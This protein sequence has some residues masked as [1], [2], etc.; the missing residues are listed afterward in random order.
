METVKFTFAIADYG[1]IALYFIAIIFLGIWG[2]RKKT[3]SGKEDFLLAGRKLTLPVFVATL[4][5]TWYGN[6]LGVG[7]FV[8]SNGIVAWV[9][10]GLPYYIAAALYA[11]LIAKKVRNTNVCTIPEQIQ[12]SYGT[13]AGKVSSVI[14]LLITIP[15]AYI[16]ML[17]IIIRMFVGLEL[18]ICIIIGAF[19]SLIYLY[20]GGF[21]ADIMA[22]TAQFVL[23]FLG[24]GI[25]LYFSVVKLGS[26][27][28]MFSRLPEL[29]KDF[30][31]GFPWQI[32][33]VW[34]IIAL[35]TFVD[36]GFHQRCSAAKSP[37]T[38]RNG[39]LV[40][41]LCWIVFDFLTL[42]TGLYA[43]AYFHDLAPITSFPVLGENILP[44]FAKGFFV[45]SMLSPIMA[46]LD[47][48]TFVSAATIG[49]DL[50][51]PYFRRRNKIL[52]SKSLTN[53]GLLITAIVGIMMAIILP[54]AVQLIYRTASIAVPGLL[55]PLL[56]SFSKSFKPSG[57]SILFLM[58]TS[59]GISA[60]W[61]IM[62]ILG[63][64]KILDLLPIIQNTEPMI[65][66]IL[67][68]LVISL[69]LLKGKIPLLRGGTK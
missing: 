59:S 4:V 64:N 23:M 45:A 13:T 24:F 42:M 5:S 27:S 9:C 57:K 61:T 35:Q 16:L 66:G 38:A 6:I 32:I 44:V 51:E 58:L 39:V 14:I 8:Y 60:I 31:G 3:S 7:E 36:P 25:L 2:T 56:F 62:K 50:L 33:I 29:H 47:G 37:E 12:K 17:G 10:F 68:S 43:K 40:S 65:P 19:I 30:F 52:S 54:S 46:S 49:N 67:V 53:I 20:K 34:Y 21:K 22:N 15:A 28:D 11:V 69:F 1:I 63:E 55:L 26:F 18:W 41:I 48:Y